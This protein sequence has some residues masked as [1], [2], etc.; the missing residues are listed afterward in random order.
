MSVSTDIKIDEKIKQKI[1]EPKK[2]KVIFVNDD[3]TPID[4]VIELLIKVFKHSQESAKK[5]TLEIHTEGSGVVGIYT[6]EIAEAKG[7]E[8]TTL[9]RG[10]GFPLVVKI[11]EE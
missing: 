2:Y 3:H 8:A 11:E 7:I 4:F 5:I 1:S 9:A 6:Y 10:N